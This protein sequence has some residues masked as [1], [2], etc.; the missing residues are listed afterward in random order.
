MI[1][2]HHFTATSCTVEL[3]LLD[4]CRTKVMLLTSANDQ[5]NNYGTQYIHQSGHH[6]VPPW[7]PCPEFHQNDHYDDNDAQNDNENWCQNHQE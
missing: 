4:C 3:S 6:C 2:K 7:S 1:N 5:Y